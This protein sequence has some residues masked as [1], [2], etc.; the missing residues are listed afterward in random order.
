MP[1]AERIMDSKLSRFR[2]GEFGFTQTPGLDSYSKQRQRQ[3]RYRGTFAE[4]RQ[5]IKEAETL[6]DL[7]FEKTGHERVFLR[8][9]WDMWPHSGVESFLEKCTLWKVVGRVLDI[10]ACRAFPSG[11]KWE[12]VSQLAAK[13]EWPPDFQ[14]DL[15]DLR[16]LTD[17]WGEDD[18][19]APTSETIGLAIK[20][21][22]SVR[23]ILHEFN[24]D[25]VF[26][27]LVPS[28]RG[29]VRVDYS[30]QN[31]LGQRKDLF[32]QVPGPVAP[33]TIVIFKRLRDKNG[34]L[35][36]VE[37]KSIPSLDEIRPFVI[38]FLS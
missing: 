37:T 1:S 30:R 10:A 33:K 22:R 12:S 31:T 29:D 21:E 4:L 25:V 17:G 20:T 7:W 19:L 27:R 16:N 28:P 23:R 26:P 36:S 8:V 6:H 2:E 32:V 11:S 13:R 3:A 15:D 14:S 18:D 34:G 35:L 5:K 38:W 9:Y 24:D